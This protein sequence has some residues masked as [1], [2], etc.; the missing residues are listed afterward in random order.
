MKAFDMA[1]CYMVF[2]LMGVMVLSFILNIIIFI[3]LCTRRVVTCETI[4]KYLLR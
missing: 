4:S 1:F 3:V 2:T